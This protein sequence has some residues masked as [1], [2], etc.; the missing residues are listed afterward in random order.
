MY[1]IDELASETHTTVRQIRRWRRNGL[2]HPPI[3]A[4]SG[5]DPY[6]WGDSHIRRLRKIVAVREQ[7]RTMD[8]IRE[9][10]DQEDP[11]L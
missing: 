6:V 5:T 4:N 1:S 10:L 9:Y 3:R 7:N 8:E 2:L 11:L